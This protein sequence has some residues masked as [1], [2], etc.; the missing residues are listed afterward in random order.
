MAM[1]TNPLYFERMI[2]SAN[3]IMVTRKIFI[4]LLIF[5]SSNR[6]KHLLPT[7]KKGRPIKAESAKNGRL[8]DCEIK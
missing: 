5:S 6:T 1:L 2:V 4:G 7:R 8:C 3:K